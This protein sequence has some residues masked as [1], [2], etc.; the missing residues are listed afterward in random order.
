MYQNG[1]VSCC[2]ILLISFIYDKLAGKNY[3]SYGFSD[4]FK[5][6][7][8]TLQL[9]TFYIFIDGNAIVFEL[10]LVSRNYRDKE[11][12]RICRVIEE[13]IYRLRNLIV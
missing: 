8:I 7:F 1:R 13:V 5:S 10:I 4:T 3:G 9:F 12:C 11:M 6:R 2:L